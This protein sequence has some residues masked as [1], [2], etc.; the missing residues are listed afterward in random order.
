MQCCRQRWRYHSAGFQYD[1]EESVEYKIDTSI[2]NKEH[3]P[4]VEIF[5]IRET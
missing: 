5:R 4:S 2:Q 3:T 1:I